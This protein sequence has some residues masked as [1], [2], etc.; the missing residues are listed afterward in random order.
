MFRYR[1]N[2]IKLFLF[3]SLGYLVLKPFYLWDHRHFVDL[4]FLPINLC[5]LYWVSTVTTWWPAAAKPGL[6]GDKLTF[7][8]F[9]SRQICFLLWLSGRLYFSE[10][11]SLYCYIADCLSDASSNPAWGVVFLGKTLSTLP[12][13]D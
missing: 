7:H 4:L 13:R 1:K 12:N 6:S 5:L 11:S 3:S 8:Y 10:L 2:I 9:T